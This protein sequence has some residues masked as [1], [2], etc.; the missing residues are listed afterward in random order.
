MPNSAPC[1][2]YSTQAG[3]CGATPTRLYIQGP[4][5]VEH[6]P[7]CPEPPPRTAAAAG[8]GR[9]PMSEINARLFI[10]AWNEAARK[11]HRK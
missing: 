1:V 6:A 11:R 8:A 2:H 4:F 5:C 10:R 3:T 7:R 9:E